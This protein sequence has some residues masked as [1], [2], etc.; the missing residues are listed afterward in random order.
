MKTLGVHLIF[1][2]ND[3]AKNVNKTSTEGINSLYLYA[4]TCVLYQK[5]QIAL[6][7]WLPPVLIEVLILGQQQKI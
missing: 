1:K 3:L 2:T 4:P 6:N 5:T 7:A